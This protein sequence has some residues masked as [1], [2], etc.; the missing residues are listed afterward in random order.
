MSTKEKIG[1]NLPKEDF[2]KIEKVRKELGLNRSQ[3][4]DLAIRSWLK[5]YV[6]QK[7][8]EEYEEGY[9]KKP[10]SIEELKSMEKAAAEAFEEEDLK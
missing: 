8:I 3:F 5:N 4:I 6:Q 2:K 10:E 7:M 9:R 1:I